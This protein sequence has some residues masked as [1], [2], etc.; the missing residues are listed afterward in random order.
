MPT[1]LAPPQP[2]TTVGWHFISNYPPFSCWTPNDFPRL[3][4][5]LSQPVPATEP[6]SL[7][8][9]IPFCRQR[10][11]YCYFRVYP[12]RSEEDVDL[13][14]GKLVEEAS[15]YGERP[16][17]VGRSLRTIY[18]GGGSP[19]YPSA[20][21]LERLCD[22]LRRRMDWRGIEEFTVE[23]EPGTVTPAKFKLLKD[24]GATRLS[25]GFQTLHEDILRHNGRDV[26]VRAC[27]EAYAQARGAG[28]D[29][30]NIDLLAGLPGESTS[31]WRHTVN[32][33]IELAPD[34]VTL[35]QLELTPN[36]VLH[37]AQQAGRRV[38]LPAWPTKRAWVAHAFEALEHA[39][40]TVASGY[41]AV[42]DPKRW[43]FAYTVDHFW[44]GADLLAL[45]ET[46]F[47]H[48]QG[49][50]YQNARTFER[51]VSQLQER[52]LPWH[53]ACALS[54]EEKLRREV[55]LQ[56]KTGRLEIAY[57]RRKFGVE[58]RTH[59]AA[60]LTELTRRELAF[61]ENDTIHLTRDALLDVDWLLPAF[62][63]P[64]HR[65]LRYS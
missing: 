45:G 13:Y 19:S 42:R 36:S 23:C 53:R 34:C 55:I 4:T 62:Y 49:V 41:M 35:Y 20:R 2:E 39:G 38:V 58:L 7:Y 30:I 27:L 44:R 16:A 40:Y 31:T 10:C 46:A 54:P 52:Q 14:L 15:I 32:R 18:F 57:F 56:L 65:G 43:R 37:R 24:A 29:Q 60:E 8:V 28:F 63:L 12:R 50:H 48:I 51:Y 9:H 61:I 11:H 26:S 64:Q 33:V 17:L 5:A 25:L 1:T 22:G 47:G 21:Q 59:F 6:I 3:E